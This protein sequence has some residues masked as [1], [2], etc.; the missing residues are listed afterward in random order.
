MCRPLPMSRTF[1]GST[2]SSL[3]QV[4]KAIV[5]STSFLHRRLHEDQFS[6]RLVERGGELVG[7]AGAITGG[8]VC[9]SGTMEAGPGSQAD[10]QGHENLPRVQMEGICHS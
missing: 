10:R 2:S 5:T 4:D 3:T 7:I 1:S 9:T 6:E 8:L